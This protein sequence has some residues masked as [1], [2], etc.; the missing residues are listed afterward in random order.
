L[1]A[2]E[3]TS[4]SK[5]VKLTNSTPNSPSKPRELKVLEGGMR[6]EKRGVRGNTIEGY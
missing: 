1:V 4:T 5:Y 2:E 3:I 6:E